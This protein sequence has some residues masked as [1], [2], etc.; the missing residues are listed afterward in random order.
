MN[1]HSTNT[2]HKAGLYKRLFAFALAHGMR[3]YERRME[4]RKIALLSNLEGHVLE[5][6][7]GTGPNLRYFNG[8]AKWFGIEPNPYMHHYLKKEAQRLGRSANLLES[9]AEQL[10]FETNSFDAVVSTLVLCSVKNPSKVLQE[11]LR[12]LKPQG[13]FIFIEHVAAP[14]GRWTKNLQNFIQPVWSL[15]GDGCHPNRDTLKA[16]MQA[17]FAHVAA[18]HFHIP[19]PI[20]GPHIAGVAVKKNEE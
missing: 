8:K 12:V 15:L 9:E 6:G 13:K 4:D 18:E 14:E 2:Y 19:V 3:S 20:A 16:I 10:P 5:I 17:G 7:A 1:P 11:V